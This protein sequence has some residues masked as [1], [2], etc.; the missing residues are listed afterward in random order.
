MLT[1]AT[2]ESR[3]PV[4]MARHQVPGAAIAIVEG[5]EI[6][7]T[8]G[9]GV[10]SVEPDGQPVRADTLFRIGSV[11]KP[12]TALMI[13]K[14][15]VRGVL[16]LDTP[17]SAYLPWLAF[18][19]TSYADQITL[20]LL[21]SHTAGLPSSYYP[22]G[23]RNPEDLEHYIRQQL[24]SY[25]FVGSPSNSYAYSNVGF[26]LAGYIA[27]AVTGIRYT[28]L[29]QREVFDPLGMTRTTFDPT[30][31][32]TYRVA[33]SHNLLPA[34]TLQVQHRFGDNAMTYP[35]GGAISCATDLA[36]LA[37]FLLNEGAWL[38]AQLATPQADCYT[39]DLAAYGLGLDVKTIRGQQVVGHDGLTG[40]FTT[41]LAI[42]PAGN[43]AVVFCNNRGFGFWDSITDIV[44]TALGLEPEITSP[45]ISS[46]SA[47]SFP[48]PSYEGCYLG[49]DRG[50]V[51]LMIKKKSL[52]LR[53]NG[54]VYDQLTPLRDDLYTQ[55]EVALGL[56]N[57][58]CVMLNSFPCRRIP[59]LPKL[60]LAELT[61]YL[62]I[63]DGA[64]RLTFTLH[65]GQ[66]TVYSEEYAQSSFCTAI[67]HRRFAC[68]FGTLQFDE[69]LQTILLG[70][71]Y[72]LTRV[73]S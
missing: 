58:G 9:F 37:R 8:N 62:G 20:R 18:S 71:T 21:L 32:I 57:S 31:A 24:P 59:E 72:P 33:L 46:I 5:D 10:T 67:G 3:I 28:E 53:W 23:K 1:P 36:K 49:A 29:M 25:Q 6:S 45:S 61:P 64:D 7:Y 35:S 55:G 44:N 51:Q 54:Q 47:Q 69:T 39:A 12:L 19:E 4:L 26:R 50:L 56:I 65:D 17:I 73:E 66:F 30:I 60:K 34:G 38:L 68:N 22:F 41:R 43:R 14:L 11:T 13:L 16:D 42:W 40:T 15:V 2:L 48:E 70:T 52:I 63:F 27:E